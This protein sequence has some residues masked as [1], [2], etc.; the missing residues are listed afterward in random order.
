MPIDF[1]KID[2]SLLSDKRRNDGLAPSTMDSAMRENPDQYATNLRLAEQSKMNIDSVAT[3]PAEVESSLK[4]DSIDFSRMADRSPRTSE[5]LSSFNNAVIA[6]DDVPILE[7]LENWSSGNILNRGIA[8]AFAFRAADPFAHETFEGVFEAGAIGFQEQLLGGKIFAVDSAFE[9]VRRGMSPALAENLRNLGIGSEEE[10]NAAKES[11]VQDLFGEFEQLQSRREKITPEGLNIVQQGIRSGIESLINM[12]PGFA[13]MLLTRNRAA[14]LAPMGV[15]TALSSYARGRVGGLGPEEAFKFAALDAAIEVGTE[16]LPTGTLQKMLTGEASGTL[17]RQAVRFLI[18]EMGT[19][20]IATLGQ[21]LNAYVFGLDEELIQ[22]EGP[23]EVVDIMLQR[24]VVTA[25]ATVVAGGA[26]IGITTSLA[27]AVG[28]VANGQR[29]QT[30]AGVQE[31]AQLD[32]LNDIAENSN[33]RQRSPETFS[34][35]I[36]DLDTDQSGYVFLDSAQVALYLQEQEGEEDP[37][38]ILLSE[39]VAKSSSTGEDVSIPIQDFA[40]VI[41]GTPHYEALRESMTLNQDTVSPFRQEQANTD[42]ENYVSRLVAEAQENVTDYI[43]AQNIFLKVRDQLVDSGQVN[44]RSANIMAQLVPAWATVFANRNNI[45]VQEAFT[46]SGLSIEGPQTGEKARLETESRTL[47]QRV[48]DTLFRTKAVETVVLTGPVSPGG[49]DAQ[50]II[51]TVTSEGGI[52]LTPQGQVLQA[53][54]GFVVSVRSFNVENL[55]HAPSLVQAT[56]KSLKNTPRNDLTVGVFDMGDGRFSIDTNV[57]VQSRDE[58]VALGI[59]FDQQS[60]FDLSTNETIETGGQGTGATEEKFQSFINATRVPDT[61][62]LNSDNMIDQPPVHNGMIALDHFSRQSGIEV[63]DPGKFGTGIR[64]TEARRSHDEFWV[65]RTSHGI[66]TGREGGY[67]KESALGNIRYRTLVPASSMYDIRNDPDGFKVGRGEAKNPNERLNLLE[68]RIKEA[69]YAGYWSDHQTLGMVA[70]TFEQIQTEQLGEVYSQPIVWPSVVTKGMNQTQFAQMLDDVVAEEHGGPLAEKTEENKQIISNAL[71]E[72]LIEEVGGNSA[73]V[74]WYKDSIRVALGYAAVLHPELATDE[75]QRQVFIMTLAITSNGATI[76]RNV[77]NAESIYSHYKETGKFDISA[78]GGFGRRGKIIAKGFEKFT[79]LINE[80]G[81]DETFKFLNKKFTVG[82]LKS[83][84]FRVVGENKSTVVFGSAIFGPKIGGAFFQNLRGN[85]DTLTMDVWFMKTWGRL[86]GTGVRN[87]KV[88]DIPRTGKDRNWMREVVAEAQTKLAARGVK[89]DTAAMQALLWYREKDLYQLNGISDQRSEA[90]DYEHEFYNLVKAKLGSTAPALGGGLS[91]GGARLTAKE[92]SELR[93]NQKAPLLQQDRGYY[94]SANSLIRLTESSNLSTFSHEFAHFILDQETKTKGSLMPEIASWFKRNAESVALEATSYSDS[95]EL[96]TVEEVN[97]FIDNDTTGDTEKDTH[98]TR[99]VHEQFARGFEQ[100]LLEGKAPSVELGKVFSTIARWLQKIYA[101]MRNNLD[102][103]LDDQMRSVFD[104]L[105]ATEEQIASAEA[106]IQAAPMFK[107]AEEAGMTTEQFDEYLGQVEDS[108]D[109]ASEILRKKL[110]AQLTRRAT[111]QWNEEKA[112]I[113]DEVK[114]KLEQTRLYLTIN[115]LR[116]GENF[117]KLDRAAVKEMVGQEFVSKAGTEF[118]KMPPQLRNMTITGGQGLHP[119]EAAGFAGYKSGNEMLADIIL[120]DPIDKVAQEAAEIEMVNRHGDILNDGTIEAEADAA[121]Q[122]EERAKLLLTELRALSRGTSVPKFDRQV[123]EQIARQQIGK[124]SYRSIHPGKYR[125]A[126]LEAKGRAEV[127]LSQ[128]NNEEAAQAKLQQLL[129]FYLGRVATEARAETIKIVESMG[130]Y[131]KKEVQQRIQRAEHGYWEQ[132]VKILNRF[133]FRKSA[134]LKGV[135][136]KNENINT[137]MRDRIEQDGDALILTP[138]ALDESYVTH[139]KNV[140]HEQLLGINDSVKNIEHVARYADKMNVLQEQITF[141]KLVNDWTAHMEQANTTKFKPQRTTVTEGKKFGALLMAQM[142]KIPWLAS[143]LDGGARVGMTH[144]ILIQPFTNALDEEFKLSK[145]SAKPVVDAMNARSRADV[146]RHNSKLFIPEIKDEN[147]DGN[148]MGHQVLAVALNTGNAS[149]LRKLLL[150]EGWAN[151]E[152]DAEIVFENPKLQAVLAHMTESDWKL[153]QLIWDQMDT[154]YPLL[155]EVHRKT[156]GQVPPKV[157]STPVKT[158]F[159]ELAGGYYPIKYDA[160]RSQQ[161]FVNEEREDA[162]IDSMFSNSTSIQA[163]VTASSTSE[164][165]GYYGPI[166]LS[167]DVVPNHFQ[168][169]IH[170]VTHHDAVRQVNKLL[171][172]KQVRDV[173]SAKL[174]PEEFAQLK[175]WL[176]DI[177]KDGRESPNKNFIDRVFGKLRFGVTLGVMGFKASTGIIQISGLSNSIAE[178]GA[179]NM[180]QAMRMILGSPSKIKAAWEFAVENSRVLEH[181]INTMDR[182]MRSAFESLEGKSGFAA[183]VQEASMKH[184]AYVQTF[185][186]DLPSW[187]AAYIKELG[188]SGDEQKAFQYADFVIEQVQ[189][190][191]ATKDMAAVMRNQSKTHR[192]F[193]MFMTFFSSLWN[194]QRDVV[195]GARSKAYSTTTV[196]AKLMFLITIPVLFEMA[197][198]GELFDEDEEEFDV[199]KMLTNIVLFPIQTVPLLRDA[200][201]GVAGDFGYNITPVAS[202][203]EKGLAGIRQIA[204]RGITDAEITKSQ[205]KNASK[206][207]GAG[208]GVPGMNQVWSTGEHLFDVIE[209]GE[210]FTAREFLFGPNR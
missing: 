46:R 55:S 7:R 40:T 94:D 87:D 193:T 97:N 74:D 45:S 25:I 11:V 160:V 176:N 21:S 59:E 103:K 5:F 111:K 75:N 183:A 19:E 188:L 53:N 51:D 38:L 95:T 156:T 64:A 124:L 99:A 172:N 109:T 36:K 96:I 203:I 191:G 164:R 131:N 56:L 4:F 170:F 127:A 171:N 210:E 63:L 157:E 70:V 161:A 115:A 86:S 182:E 206:L 98:I 141:K 43:E 81:L 35:F 31:Q 208:L 30:A 118:I 209:N 13:A 14:L 117:V 195:R 123:I 197:L 42:A 166:R 186:V 122:N 101:S 119:D 32:E 73:A 196:A 154:L 28:V 185:M 130:R 205:I 177:A 58:A 16:F 54:S 151:P 34:Q 82:E 145:L 144:D 62:G 135:D 102:V 92:R 108:K 155:S 198:R 202:V 65:D 137:W 10:F 139:W 105:L 134:T 27:K 83:I 15:Q 93:R 142:T 106:R 72:E 201:S 165:T 52:S 41:A 129:N 132:I 173:I 136:E 133:E 150:G 120:A 80:L 180:A 18:Q 1:D 47:F 84:G 121:V 44:E 60:V 167:L 148:L 181:R 76:K 152:N 204:I 57:T 113:A 138:A 153:V 114:A 189:G 71:V 200:A 190:S 116:T 50:Q 68:K 49:V 104:R 110:I 174:G 194:A 78:G 159:G 69:G 168:E 178:V 6:Q 24:A 143:W 169:V 128:K 184:I 163:S 8:A 207:I 107:T 37:A 77:S 100:Y 17:T 22:A 187:Y 179:S 90:T 146:R 3:D 23:A 112:D 88:V 125:K 162:Q 26:Q 61:T 149:N 20:Q 66:A 67:K 91:S 12:S 192:I 140:P 48:K 79:D 147:N 39:Q 126:E 158:P 33:L 199:Q 9:T 29:E 2:F 89:L 85:W 175:P